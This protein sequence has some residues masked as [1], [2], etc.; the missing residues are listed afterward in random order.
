MDTVD[1]LGESLKVVDDVT[2]VGGE[3]ELGDLVTKAGELLVGRAE[4]SLALLGKVEDEDRLVDLDGLGTSLLELG[5]ELLV[6]G[7]EV[8]KKVN[9]VD[10]LATVG[11]AEVEERDG[12]NDDGAGGDAS[13]LGLL[14]VGDDLGGSGQGEL[15]VVLESGLDV[16]VVGVEPLDHLQT[17][18]INALLLVTTAHG[19]V[20]VDGV[21]AIL[22]VALGNGAEVL[23]VV[24]DVVVESEVT[25]GDDIDTGILL[26]L[27]VGKTE[28]LG[29]GNEIG[30]RDLATPVYTRESWCQRLIRLRAY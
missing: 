30:L 15:L 14:E 3:D 24:Q 13:L 7:E 28:T 1:V 16:V 29:L 23:D 11:L 5:Q 4:S 2:E 19:E 26:D 27:P 20:L 21:E 8:V 10:R 25:A 17:G 6:D 22:G 18:D 12:A 9:G